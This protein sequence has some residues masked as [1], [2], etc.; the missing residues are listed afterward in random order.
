MRKLRLSRFLR[1]RHPAAPAGAAA[2]A[3]AAVTAGAAAEPR[4]LT[5]PAVAWLLGIAGLAA[6]NWWILVPLVPG[7]MKSPSELFSNM[8]VTGQPYAAAMQHADLASGLLLAGAFLAIGSRGILAARREWVAM[9]VFAIAGALGGI[10]PEVCA[11]EVSVAC[12]SVEWKF[13]LPVSQYLHMA[14]GI[15]E[16]AAITFAL[17]L[18]VRRTRDERTR[19]AR[20][21]RELAI[22][23]LVGYPLL[24]AAYLTDWLGG[25]VEPVFFVGFTVMVLTQLAERTKFAWRADLP[26]RGAAGTSQ[27]GG[28]GAA[29]RRGRERG[30]H[31]AGDRRGLAA[32]LPGGH[33]AV[34]QPGRAALAIAPGMSRS[35]RRAGARA[36][37]LKLIWQAG[38]LVA[39]PEAGQA[40]EVGDE[41]FVLV[42]GIRGGDRVHQ[43]LVEGWPASP[44]EHSAAEV[45]QPRFAEVAV[46]VDREVGIGHRGRRPAS[47][48]SRGRRG[49]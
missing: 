31:R 7:L 19:S 6:Y 32:S 1:G 43:Q 35:A 17:L 2:A 21:Y 23:A 36:N 22:G 28:A 8:E 13:Q 29:H 45:R 24:G 34:G 44:V 15:V 20:I 49:R 10:F 41:P 25:L 16:F 39:Q 42:S 14:V 12:R 3:G 33:G 47:R 9:M 11:D 4:P 27:A 5:G 26:G 37:S 46:G 30:H 38:C 18:A 48:R 40:A